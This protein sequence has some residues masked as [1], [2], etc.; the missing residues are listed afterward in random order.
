MISCRLG[1]APFGRPA[2]QLVARWNWQ[3]KLFK[4]SADGRYD[5]KSAIGDAAVKLNLILLSLLAEGKYA[6]REQFNDEPLQI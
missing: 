6:T 5:V 2:V 3:G 1:G 4:W